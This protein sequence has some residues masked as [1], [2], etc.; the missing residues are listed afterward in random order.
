MTEMP[1][2]DLVVVGGGLAGLTAG[3]R[4]AELGRKVLLLEKEAGE[5]YVCNSRLAGGI[6]HIA[7][8]DCRRPADELLGV[9][10]AATAGKVSEAQAQALAG[11]APRFLAWL[12]EK[13]VRFMRFG[14]ADWQRWCLAPPRPLAP[15]IVWEG[16]G[17]DVT[18]RRLTD[19][20]KAG[21]GTIALGAAASALR[22]EDG[23]CVGV[24]YAQGGREIE[25]RAHAVLIADGGFQADAELFRQYIG[26]RPD[27]LVRRNAGNAT[28]AGLRMAVAAGAAITG[29]NNFYG[30]LL[31]RDALTN[32]NLWPYPEVDAIAC[33]GIVVGADGRRLTDE[34]RGGIGMANFIARLDDP[35]SAT[36]IFDAAIWDGPGRT[37][38]FPAN[39]YVEKFGGTVLRAGSVAELAEKIGVPAANLAATVDTYNTH[40]RQGTCDRMVPPRGAAAYV[41]GA[42]TPPV[43]I[44]K[45]PLMALPL[46]VG[47]TYTM[48][49]IEIDG[50]GQVL[51][52]DGTVIPGLYAAGTT[53]GGMEGGGDNGRVGYVGAMMRAGVFGLR[54]AERARAIAEAGGAGVTG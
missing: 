21:G 30:H 3:A 10:R 36:A 39:P 22:M 24:A 18:L 49:G 14:A 48:G 43:P 52:P 47:I 38:R 50:H 13:G 29:V 23:R 16:Y 26:P 51:R 42:T 28:G 15:G 45:A 31:S 19:A 7:Y 40:V 17:S 5:R 11:D 20:F 1:K 35:A 33:A 4:S 46:C 54:A 41:N 34:S 2:W 32:A 6:L 27:R 12:E 9:I 53:T 37:A 25:A 8:H 44:E